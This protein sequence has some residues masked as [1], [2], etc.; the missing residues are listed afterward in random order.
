[1]P[2][3]GFGLVAR[4]EVAEDELV[5]MGVEGDLGG[6]CGCAVVGFLGEEGVCLGEGGFVVEAGDALQE[7]GQLGTVGG[8]GAVGVGAHGVGGC[9]EPVVGDEGAV[10]WVG[11]VHACFDVVDL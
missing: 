5:G 11:P 3:G 10:G 8:V 7:F 2:A 4:G 6:L 9:G 1:M